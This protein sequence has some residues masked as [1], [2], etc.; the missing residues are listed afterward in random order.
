M[1][2]FT[3]CSCLAE[4][5]AQAAF[6]SV[7]LHGRESFH[8]GMLSWIIRCV[9]EK[10]LTVLSL[11]MQDE[12]IAQLPAWAVALAGCC[13]T[14]RA[15][16]DIVAVIC[17]MYSCCPELQQHQPLLVTAICQLAASLA[18]RLQ[19]TATNTEAPGMRS[20]SGAALRSTCG[21]L[22]LSL[23]NLFMPQ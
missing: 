10:A 19:Q 12:A 13:W 1:G 3:W 22:C 7:Q 9:Q 21:R 5:A 17:A 4:G 18:T 23:R 2:H 16:E 20:G 8:A 15:L 14:T 6:V 11:D